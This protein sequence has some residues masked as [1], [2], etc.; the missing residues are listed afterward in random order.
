MVEKSFLKLS[1]L[2]SQKSYLGTLLVE[3]D[4]VIVG[5]L[6]ILNTGEWCDTLDCKTPEAIRSE[7]DE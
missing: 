5:Q 7:N 3:S 1:K 4:F 2:V 6:I